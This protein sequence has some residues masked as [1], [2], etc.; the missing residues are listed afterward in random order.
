MS[1]QIDAKTLNT[2]IESPGVKILDAS[3]ALD[4]SNMRLAY[5]NEHIDGAQFFDLNEICDQ[6]D[7]LPHMAPSPE[8]FARKIG[9]LGISEQD[10]VVIYDAFGLFSAARVWWIF[11]LMGHE[12]ISILRGGLPAWKAQ[13][14]EVTHKVETATKASYLPNPKPH[15]CLDIK[16]LKTL[17]NTAKTLILDARPKARFDGSA[18]EPRAGL[19]SGH[20]PASHNLPATEL[21]ADGA[22][23]PVKDLKSIF[24]SL[25]MSDNRHII[26]TCGSGVTAAIITLAL[27]EIGYKN[28]QLYDGSW[29]EWGQ[30]HLDT[31]VVT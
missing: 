10:H 9:A 26:T 1:Q 14:F 22:L 31:E 13:G 30:K 17:K 2:L 11:K 6:I 20:M 27:Y 15:L 12:H 29:A 16:A 21:I 4:G 5:D 3:W 28:T 25:P 7:P 8:V 24:S 23:K 19:R 18:P